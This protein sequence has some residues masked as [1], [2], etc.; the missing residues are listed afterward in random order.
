[1]N[2]FET[3]QAQGNVLQ[4]T[5]TNQAHYA[6]V[7][8]PIPQQ[9][10]ETGFREAL[11]GSLEEVNSQQMSHEQLSIQSIVNP[12]SVDPH[13]LTI[14]AAKATTSLSITRNVV[15]RVIQAYRDITNL[16]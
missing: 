12:E 5:R 10:Q 7:R 4:L 3:A 15:D 11:V 14:A 16:R 1:M 2:L 13:D 8:E 9:P 6:G